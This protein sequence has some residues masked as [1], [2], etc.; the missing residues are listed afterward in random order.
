MRL[1]RRHSGMTVLELMIVLAIIG[2]A[3]LLVRSGFRM[4]TKA[5]LVEN[6]TEMAAVLKRTSQLAI[7]HGEMHRVTFD[8][9]KHAYIVEIC[10]GAKGIQRNEKRIEQDEVKRLL[11]RGKEKAKELPQT[12]AVSDDPEAATKRA[13]AL[14][15]HHIADRTCVPANDPIS[16][17]AEGKGFLRQLRVK[18]GIKLKEIWVQHRDDSVTKGQVSIYF[19]PQGSAEKAVV[20]ITDGDETF[21]I[22]VHGLTGRVQLI[23]GVLRD[24]NDHMLRNV[25]GDKDAKREDAP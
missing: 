3:A 20:E 14:V 9:E 15:G 12:S 6:A 17:D 18:K 21:T 5:D 4:I 8:F 23:D 22:L 13:L 10:A 19:F 11:D 16:G 24:V 7:E 2:A 1:S 25:M